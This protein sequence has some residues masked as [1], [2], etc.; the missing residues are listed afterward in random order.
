[1][2]ENKKDSI[3]DLAECEDLM[4]RYAMLP[5]IVEHSRQVMRVSLA[6]TDHL[7]EG[8]SINRDLI[9]AAAL[10]HDITK[11]RSLQTGEKHADSGGVLLRK[12]GF[13]RVAEIVEQHV[14]IPDLNLQGGLE[15]REIVY[16]ADKRVM[17]N[18]IVGLDERVDDLIKR[19]AT[20][21]KIRRRILLNKNQA[22]AVER[23][24]SGFMKMDIH[25]A[26]GKLVAHDRDKP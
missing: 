4:V 26:I 10:L 25:Q 6:I 22:L 7:Q 13:R 2:M 16:Y 20:D 15:E 14:T 8:L 5:N 18:V 9:V 23:K 1:M 17:H 3:P 11:T 21:E 19:Y 12:L 24:I